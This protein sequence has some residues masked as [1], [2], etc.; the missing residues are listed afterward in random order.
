MAPASS[1]LPFR[2]VFAGFGLAI[3]ATFLLMA[4]VVAIPFLILRSR[5][6]RAAS[7]QYA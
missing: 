2:H 4:A 5:M 7:P 1:F 3:I 6:R